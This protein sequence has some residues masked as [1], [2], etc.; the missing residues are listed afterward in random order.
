MVSKNIPKLEDMYIPKAFKLYQMPKNYTKWPSNN[1]NLLKIPHDHEI[2]RNS[3]LQGIQKDTKLG[4]LVCILPSGN[5]GCNVHLEFV[6][7]NKQ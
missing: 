6:S 4:F 3:P 2:Y 5:P 1:S 7:Q